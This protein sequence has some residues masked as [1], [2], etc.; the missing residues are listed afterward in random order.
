[1]NAPVENIVAE[2]VADTSKTIAFPSGAAVMGDPCYL[3][4]LR[5]KVGP[6]ILQTFLEGD[7]DTYEI[8][9]CV[10]I[11]V[12]AEMPIRLTHRDG[13][14]AEWELGDWDQPHRDRGDYTGVVLGVDSGQMSIIDLGTFLTS[15]VERDYEDIRIYEH[16]NSGK[17]LQYLVDF[18]RY[19]SPIASEGGKTM[20]ELNATGKWQELPFQGTIDWSYS[21]LCNCHDNDNDA[22]VLGG[23]GLV[24]GTGYGDGGY[25]TGIW[26]TDGKASQICIVFL[27]DDENEDDNYEDEEDEDV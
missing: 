26:F 7:D 24:T 4:R 10:L 23:R 8:E 27:G 3:G 9:D 6:E 14:I 13:R 5:Q 17:R 2:E 11:K 15:W 12:P 1:M 22:A 16:K 18:I 20:N 25:D 19:D 21:G